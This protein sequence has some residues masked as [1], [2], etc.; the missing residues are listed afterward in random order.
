MSPHHE[1]PAVADY[2]HYFLG[3]IIISD[4]DGEK[5]IIDGQQRLTTLTL[6][7]I[8]LQHQLED[9]EQRGQLAELIFSQKFGRRSFNLDIPERTACMEALYSGQEF[10]GQRAARVNGQHHGPLRGHRRV[11]PRGATRDERC[12]TSSTG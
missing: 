8:F 5:F 10:V 11:L 7:L 9:A 12:P 1:R 4:K 3:S 2:G 6:L